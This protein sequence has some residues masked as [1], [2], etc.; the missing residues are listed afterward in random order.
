MRKSTSA[1]SKPKTTQPLPVVD[2]GD[3]VP[4]TTHAEMEAGGGENG[5]N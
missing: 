2:I 5:E 3:E 4:E 1:Q